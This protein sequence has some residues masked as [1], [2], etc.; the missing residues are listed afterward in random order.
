MFA[1]TL[2]YSRWFWFLFGAAV[3]L[4]FLFAAIIGLGD[5]EAYYW[6]WSR[7]LQWSYY[8]HPP[9]LAWMIRAATTLLG[10]DPWVV[11][12]PSLVCGLTTLHFI[13]YLG[14][15]LLG[16][17]AAQ[18]AVVLAIITPL[19]ALGS[20]LA[21]P[22]APMGALWLAAAYCGFHATQGRFT[23]FWLT[24]TGACLGMGFLAKYPIVLAGVSILIF[25]GFHWRLRLLRQSGFYMG[26]LLFGACTLPV[27][28]WNQQHGWPSFAFHL[29]DRQTGGLSL[30]RWTQFVFSQVGLITPYVFVASILAIR[31]MWILRRDPRH[32]FLL[33]MIL[34]TLLVFSVQPVAAEFKPHWLAPI[35]PF[36]FLGVAQVFIQ[37]EE[38]LRHRRLWNFTWVFCLLVA[39]V[40]YANT[41]HPVVGRLHSLVSRGPWSPKMD[42]AQDVLGWPEAHEW[43]KNLIRKSPAPTVVAS[44]RYQLVSQLSYA[45]RDTGYFVERLGGMR[46][47]YTFL[48]RP[49]L[50][51]LPAGFQYKILFVSDHRYPKKPEE[52]GLQNCQ[53]AEPLVVGRGRFAVHEFYAHLCDPR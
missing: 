6:D 16:Q 7:T 40:F 42:P 21:V 25:W 37:L 41:Q 12:L 32:L 30:L 20:L 50:S 33:C 11:R 49:S 24:A 35:F 53:S 8:D 19:F 14:R 9:L 46:D 1:L 47:A 18:G 13:Y 4:R 27:L 45:G 26:I 51:S 2:P 44:W 48:P 36:L 31:R 52:V 38:Q 17:R 43:I 10:H 39:G 29:Q 15:D 5:D 28:W 34:P 22:D 3:M 23:Q